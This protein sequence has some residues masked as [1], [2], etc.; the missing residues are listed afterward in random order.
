MPAMELINTVDLGELTVPPFVE[1]GGKKHFG[2]GDAATHLVQ[3]FTNSFLQA[4]NGDIYRP[5]SQGKG[6]TEPVTV[7]AELP[8]LQVFLDGPEGAEAEV[9]V[10]SGIWDAT[11]KEW[12]VPPAS[13]MLFR[14]AWQQIG[15]FGQ[16]VFTYTPGHIYYFRLS[17]PAARTIEAM[18]AE[19]F[20]LQESFLEEA[21][22]PPPS[23]LVMLI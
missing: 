5:D 7:F 11:A 22:P 14:G 2:G 19:G 3:E 18:R 4:N 16:P 1:E 12:V 6:A 20:N 15:S 17:I 13:S 10:E 9:P 23:A 21:V 8:E